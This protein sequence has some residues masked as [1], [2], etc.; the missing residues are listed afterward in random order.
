MDA[1]KKAVLMAKLKAGREKT[2]AMRAEAKEKGL[3]DPKPRKAR[4]SKKLAVDPTAH[5]ASN[6]SI[7]GIDAAVPSARDVV[8]DKPVDPTPSKS[9]Q[10]DVP[11]LPDEAG[12]KK[13]VRNAEKKPVRAPKRDVATTGK[14]EAY[15]GNELLRSQESGMMAIETMLPGQKESI[16][17]VLTKNKKMRVLAPKAN[18]EPANAAG[19]NNATVQDVT[20]HIPDVKAVEGRAPFSFSA[21][22]KTLYQ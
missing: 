12:R 1:E 7:P 20:K 13:I 21:I 18:P 15:S 19:G 8:A 4:K 22:R 9:A 3:P 5:K 10:I 14:P 2:K 11:N 16:K 17:E 6:E